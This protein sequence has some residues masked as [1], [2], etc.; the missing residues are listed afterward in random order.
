MATAERSARA[1]AEDSAARSAAGRLCGE[2]FMGF[3]C[4]T[5]VT[6]YTPIDAHRA[7][8]LRDA[9]GHH[10]RVAAAVLVKLEPRLGQDVLRALLE[11]ADAR[12]EPE[13]LG[14]EG[15]HLLHPL[16]LR[17]QAGVLDH[18]LADPPVVVERQDVEGA[19]LG[20][21]RQVGVVQEGHARDHRLVD[22]E[23]EELVYVLLDGLL[24]AVDQ[25]LAPDGV[26]GEVVEQPGVAPRRLAYLL[27]VVAVDKRAHALVREYLVQEA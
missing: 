5:W 9:L 15:D 16:L 22:F 25:L 21:V 1:P 19:D 18:L 6:M 7:L 27:V 12:E 8:R 14:R 13:A 11:A 24:R 4:L 17:L 2:V 3:G 10:L 26:A 20:R 23:H